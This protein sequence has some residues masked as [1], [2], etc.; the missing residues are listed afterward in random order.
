MNKLLFTLLLSAGIC[1][2]VFA[3]DSSSSL[4]SLSNGDFNNPRNFK[5]LLDSS[6][7]FYNDGHYTKS[8]ELNLDIL[9]M[10]FAMKKPYYIHQGYRY[11][12][13]DYLVLNDTVLAEENMKKSEYYAKLSNNDT[14]TAVT[15][16]DL[17]NMYSTHKKYQKA[18]EFHDKS[19]DGFGKFTIQ[20]DWQK[21]IIIP[22]SQ[23]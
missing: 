1:S 18:L 2:T 11:L 20:Q 16:M 17:A 6:N 21:H 14:A 10:A 12:A 8:L 15:F 19:I 7:N 23:L 5:K 4:D 9:K 22:Y 3:Q 13:Y